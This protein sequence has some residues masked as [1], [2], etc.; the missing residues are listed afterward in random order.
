MKSFK[1]F[2]YVIYTLLFLCTLLMAYLNDSIVATF[3]IEKV[4]QFWIYW[5]I[6]GFVLLMLESVFEN[7]H[8]SSVR[9]KHEKLNRENNELKAKLYDRYVAGERTTLL[10]TSQSSIESKDDI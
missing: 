4:N 10:P 1:P 3:T 8:I 2:L 6:L 5:A 7:I 9:R